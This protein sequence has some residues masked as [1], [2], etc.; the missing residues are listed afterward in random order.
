MGLEITSTS[1]ADTKPNYTV[2]T[3][4]AASVVVAD[5]EL[6]VFVGSTVQTQVEANNGILQCI[7]ALREIQWP[8]PATTTFASAVYDTKT[9]VL[10]VEPGGAL[11]TLTEDVVALIRGLDYSPAGCSSSAHGRRMIEMYLEDDKAA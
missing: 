10:T 3:T 1:R 4:A 5:G 6:V 11:P 7:Q 9:N 8:N 2:A